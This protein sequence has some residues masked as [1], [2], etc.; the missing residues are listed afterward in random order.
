[1]LVWDSAHALGRTAK[2]SAPVKNNVMNEKG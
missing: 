1:M 2:P